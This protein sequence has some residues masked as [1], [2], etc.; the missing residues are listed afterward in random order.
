MIH[1]DAETE[2][3]AVDREWRD[4][5]V[6]LTEALLDLDAEAHACLDTLWQVETTHDEVTTHAARLAVAAKMTKAR[7][8]F[9]VAAERVGRCLGVTL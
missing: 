3:E 6:S 8:D 7:H 4:A 1:A 5:R 9:R 2:T